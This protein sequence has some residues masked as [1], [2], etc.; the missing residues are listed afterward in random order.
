MRGLLAEF[1]AAGGA[2]I[3]VVTGSH[4]RDQFAEY[5][6]LARG[7]GLLASRGS[8]FHGPSDGGAELGGIPPLPE[9]LVPVWHDW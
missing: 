6:A 2:A 1:Q 4:R 7:F 8:D 3:E 5:A 9:G